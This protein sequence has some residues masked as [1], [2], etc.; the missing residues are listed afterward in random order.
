M[1]KLVS[2]NPA[3][4][5]SIVG[6]VD[7][8]T[9]KEIAD[10]VMQANQAKTFWKELGVKGRIEL[11]EPIRD[12]FKDRTEEIANLISKE[13][14]KVISESKSEVVR[15]IEELTWFLDNGPRAL[16]DTVTL[17]DETSF[18]RIVYEPYGV[19]ASI[20]PWNFPF[21]MSI[22]GIFPNL[23]AGNPVVFKI[24]KECVL[25]GKL[26]EKII[27]N[28]SLPTGV[29]S[30]VYG[31][32][33]VGKKLTESDI[34]LIWFTGSTEVGKS[35]YK[36]AADKF[37]KVVLE[38]GGSNPCVV[39]D[40][41]DIEKAALVIFGGRFRHCGQVCSALKRLIVHEKVVDKLTLAL[42]KIVERQKVGNPLDTKSDLGSLINKHQQIVIKSQ[43]QD[44]LDKG[45]EI[46]AQTKL[47]K[48]LKGAFFPPTLLSH[49]TPDMKVWHEEVFGPIFPIITFKTEREAIDLANDTDYGLGARVMSEDIKRAERVASKIDAGSIT[50]NYEANFLAC[51]PF[52]GYK[53]S[54][55]GRERGIHGLQ[56][57]CQVKVIQNS[58]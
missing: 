22:W 4:N 56:E 2:T 54:G 6:E 21:G 7:I 44:A 19:A 13:T 36:T 58:K 28:H 39:F 45:A 32:G 12:E 48:D 40:D 8:S 15:Y 29:F 41:I 47:S 49:I 9:D 3:E 5:Y 10:K 35:L 51:D 42:R 30:E 16:K 18:H 50:L 17:D 25:V 1:T 43:L 57:L 46:V 33:D 34:D 24:S 55:I 31:A 38:M 53:N 37:I 20:A 26:I 11:L 27:L 14:G 52:G 23:I